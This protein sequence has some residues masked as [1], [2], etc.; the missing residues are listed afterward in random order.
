MIT[1]AT[2]LLKRRRSHVLM[3]HAGK[4]HFGGAFKVLA[5]SPDATIRED[6][7]QLSL[8]PKRHVS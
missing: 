5:A 2:Q 8:L 4:A 7:D 6:V 3:L 1:C